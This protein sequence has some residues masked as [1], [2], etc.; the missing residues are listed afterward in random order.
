MLIFTALGKV[1]LRAIA[2]SFVGI[3]AVALAMLVGALGSGGSEAL[4]VASFVVF[5]GFGWSLLPT[6]RESLVLTIIAVVAWSYLG[7]WVS[8]FGEPHVRGWMLAPLII[9]TCTVLICLLIRPPRY[10]HRFAKPH[11]PNNLSEGST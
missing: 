8:Q 6:I 7:Y 2:A 4:H 5:F 10:I 11:K 9:S 3:A 1:I